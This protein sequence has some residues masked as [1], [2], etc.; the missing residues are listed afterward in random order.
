MNKIGYAFFV[1][2]LGATALLGAGGKEEPEY[3]RANG[4]ESWTY[5]YDLS[6]QEEGLY[7]I[8][9]EGE[10]RAGNVSQAGPFNLYIDGESDLPQTAVVSPVAGSLIKDNLNV[11]GSASDDDG[12]AL[13]E[14][15]LDGGAYAACEGTE[16]W[17]YYIPLG[18]LTDGHHEISLRATDVN[19]LTG[20]ENTVSFGVDKD[21]PR[22]RIDSPEKGAFLK[23]TVL[24]SGTVED[25]SGLSDLYITHRESGVTDRV[26]LKFDKEAGLYRFAYK[27]STKD[28]EEGVHNLT[29]A[30]TDVSGFRGEDNFLFFADNTPPELEI[31][32]PGEDERVNG[33]V[34]IGGFVR[35]DVGVKRIFLRLADGEEREAAVLPGSSYWQVNLSLEGIPY[36]SRTVEI[37]AEDNSG[38]VSE[39]KIKILHDEKSDL[40]V[41]SLFGPER[42]GVEEETVQLG[43]IARDDDGIRAIEYSLDGESP[44]REMACEG[45]VLEL[46]GL[47]PGRHKLVARAVDT[48]DKL[49]ET[50]QL[51]FT[52]PKLSQKNPLAPVEEIRFSAGGPLLLTESGI[53]VEGTAPGRGN[54]L[55]YALLNGEDPVYENL[56]RDGDGGFRLEIPA[57][58]LT[59]G[60]YALAFRSQSEEGNFSENL[61]LISRDSQPPELTLLSPG[62]EEILNG[63]ILLAGKVQDQSGDVLVEISDDG[64][65]YLPVEGGK[66][67][68]HEI[69]LNRYEGDPS[70]TLRLS[71]SRGLSRLVPLS[72]GQNADADIPRVI[73]DYPLA[74]SLVNGP[75]GLNGTA[76]DDDGIGA[77]LYRVGEE[78]WHRTEGSYSFSLPFDPGDRPD[79]DFTVYL[80]CEDL[81]G[82][83]SSVVE[84]TFS[85]SRK[86]PEIMIDSPVPED[87]LKG[88]GVLQGTAKD[89]NGIAGVYVSTDNGLS[90]QKAR[91]EENWVYSLDTTVLPDGPLSLF[92]KAVDRAG[93]E[94]YFTSLIN[95]DNR[96]PSIKLDFPRGNDEIFRRFTIEGVVSDLNSLEEVNYTLA[97]RDDPQEGSEWAYSLLKGEERT[98][99]INRTVDLSERESGWYILSLTAVDRAGNRSRIS[100]DIYLNG[101]ADRAGVSLLYPLEGAGQSGAVLIEG[102]LEKGGDSGGVDLFLDG[103]STGT[104]LAGEDGFFHFTLDGETLTRGDH[105]LLARSG[106]SQTE[107]RH[108]TYDGEGPWISFEG[109]ESGDFL[110]ERTFITG[111]TGYGDVPLDRI[112]YSFD[113]GRSFRIL[114]GGKVSR[115]KGEDGASWKVR[116]ETESYPDGDLPVIAKAYYGDGSQAT[117]E[118]LLKVDKTAPQITINAPSEGESFNDVLTVSGDTEDSNGMSGVAL[119]LREGDKSGYELPSFVQGL[120]LDFQV[121]GA[122]FGEQGVGLTFFE[123][124]VK[125][126][127]QAGIAPPG[128]FSGLVLG[129][130]LL[131]NVATIPYSYVLGPDWADFSTSL[132]VGANFSYFT[133]SGESLGFS[134]DG[135]VL[136]SILFQWELIKFETDRWSVLNDYSLYVEES[137]WFISSDVQAGLVPRFS[138]GCR[139]GIF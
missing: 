104:A 26:G 131:A 28:F 42:T 134:S 88:V 111:R 105:V 99:R 78:E 17:D 67:F 83:E 123:D 85:V 68:S 38:N 30:T 90:Y 23:D 135:V 94:S 14:I 137:L 55:S 118:I 24:L 15:S 13:V 5:S 84:R 139:V 101:E 112:E 89:D 81:N 21:I 106:N 58:N 57:E 63:K 31:L 73:L 48:N 95:I 87:I 93:M 18:N 2:I 86:S 56:A 71:D 98:L 102:T 92:I 47:E 91:G 125:L 130:K 126:Q 66:S 74:D 116:I 25:R 75:V 120:F 96:A 119:L 129:G 97:S 109:Y 44:R 40:P 49:G 35:D 54:T 27:I 62:P 61:I 108:F 69:D 4:L 53:L 46:T 79:G 43:L 29:L 22:I 77:V 12:I 65:N 10:D 41:L 36:G 80:K 39:E 127:V 136:G 117:A 132:A 103:E 45:T 133:M 6:S 37:V 64:E 20:P 7:N 124:N 16:F 82:R 1:L 3:N 34:L 60:Q 59:D 138:V 33:E 113:K 52:V 107:E 11:V 72:I 122:T 19:G 8:I 100:R 128:R 110:T 76:L 9:V 70:L 121:L 32:T 114:P 115:R 51:S 50:E